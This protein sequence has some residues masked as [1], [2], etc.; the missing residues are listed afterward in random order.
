[1][2]T[3]PTV[4]NEIREQISRI[5]G[6]AGK[7]WIPIVIVIVLTGCAAGYFYLRKKK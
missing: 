6:K 4:I 5:T 2:K 7:I 3:V 1:M